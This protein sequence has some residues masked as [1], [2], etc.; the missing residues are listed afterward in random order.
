MLY[1]VAGDRRQEL[2]A[3]TTEKEKAAVL[4]IA[5]EQVLRSESGFW[6]KAAITARNAADKLLEQ[7]QKRSMPNPVFNALIDLMAGKDVDFS[8]NLEQLGE[9]GV[10]AYH[11]THLCAIVHCFVGDAKFTYFARRGKKL[12]LSAGSGCAPS[13]VEIGVF[14]V[15]QQPVHASPANGPGT[16]RA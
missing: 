6:D 10:N 8:K 2:K 15:E 7:L 9:S 13:L 5:L 1:G 11:L 12:T 3:A 14:R 16:G 4:V